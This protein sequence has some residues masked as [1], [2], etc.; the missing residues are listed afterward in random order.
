MK[1]LSA[2]FVAVTSASL[3]V[4]SSASLANPRHIHRVHHAVAP[5]ESMDDVGVMNVKGE[6]NYKAEVP[7]PM[8]CPALRVLND[9]FYVGIGASYDS[10][11]IRNSLY[12]VNTAGAITNPST[13]EVIGATGWNGELELGYGRYFD[14]FYLGAELAAAISN[15]EAKATSID[16]DGDVD[17]SQRVRARDSYSASLIGGVKLSEASLAYI[18]AG[19]INTKFRA[20]T[21]IEGDELSAAVSESVSKRKGGGV[22]GVGIETYLADNLSLRGEFD[23]ACYKSFSLNHFPPVLGVTTP[24]AVSK[25]KPSNNSYTLSLI[26]HFA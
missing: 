23:H 16:I 13:H 26:Y 7:A 12:T 8:P 10:Y 4:A 17:A 11:R 14:Q 24:I 1:K 2:I 22:F 15:A 19:Y 9:G 25:F 6:A 21:V 5:S 18:R 20:N 3:L